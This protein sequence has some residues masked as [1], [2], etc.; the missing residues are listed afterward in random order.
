MTES[1]TN[2]NLIHGMTVKEWEAEINKMPNPFSQVVRTKLGEVSRMVFVP[3]YPGPNRVSPIVTLKNPDIWKRVSNIG[4]EVLV[5]KNNSYLWPRLEYKVSGLSSVK[6]YVTSLEFHRVG[7]DSVGYSGQW[8]EDES[9]YF[10]HRAP[11]AMVDESWKSGLVYSEVATGR[12]MQ[13]DGVSFSV[14][15]RDPA[16][17]YD[18]LDEFADNTLQVKTGYRFVPVF[19]VHEILPDGSRDFLGSTILEETLFVVVFHYHSTKFI[20]TKLSLYV[21]EPEKFIPSP[22][23]ILI[24]KFCK[25]VSPP[26]APVVTLKNMDVWSELAK[27]GHEVPVTT[28]GRSLFPKLDYK[29]EN[30]IPERMYRVSLKFRQMG[31]IKY[32][33]KK[34]RWI[35]DEEPNFYFEGKVSEVVFTGDQSGMKWMEEGI[36]SESILIYAINEKNELKALFCGSMLGV[37]ANFRYLPILTLFEE[38]DGTGRRPLSWDYFFGET[39]FVPTTAYLNANMKQMKNR[40]EAKALHEHMQGKVLRPNN[41]SLPGPSTR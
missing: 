36:N 32:N 39:V 8:H 30:R 33:S 21:D 41:P 28:T 10:P 5:D 3:N 4:I 2:Q 40:L 27:Y 19:S 11:L 22:K 13:A 15:L 16:I 14:Q 25:F 35:C 12:E 31:E 7:F 17:D 9:R 1:P 38:E 26:G 23:N 37:R 20:S 29:F 34:Q 24:S 6:N 18:Y